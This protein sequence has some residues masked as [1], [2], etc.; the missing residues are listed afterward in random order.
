MGK[1]LKK[2]A[3]KLG[4]T[5]QQKYTFYARPKKMKMKFSKYKPDLAY[6][7]ENFIKSIDP[8]VKSAE[9]GGG[10]NNTFYFLSPQTN[11][12]AEI[13]DKMSGMVVHN[14][15]NHTVQIDLYTDNVD[16]VKAI[17]ADINSIW[18]D[19]VI[20]HLNIDKLASKYKVRQE[21][22]INAWNSFL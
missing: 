13:A 5:N 6:K 22:I 15:N 21:D 16:Y 20:P 10:R 3:A 8:S 9:S 12:Y 19:G 2:E 14:P 18:D 17:V 1:Q 11:F 4:L 7:V